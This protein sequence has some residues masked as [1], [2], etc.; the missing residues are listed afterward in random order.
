MMQPD[1]IPV[2]APGM[3]ANS[4]NVDVNA[5]TSSQHSHHHNHPSHH[6][7]HSRESVNMRRVLS[8]HG[9]TYIR[10]VTDKVIR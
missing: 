10:R 5:P 7:R 3:G 1:L 9:T 2:N 8:K 6:V 4:Q